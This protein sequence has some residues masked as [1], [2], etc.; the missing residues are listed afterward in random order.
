MVI[1]QFNTVLIIG[2]RKLSITIEETSIRYILRLLIMLLLYILNFKKR[3]FKKY[4]LQGLFHYA[5][6]QNTVVLQ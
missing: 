1:R 3:L 2:N 4:I 6:Q 5:R